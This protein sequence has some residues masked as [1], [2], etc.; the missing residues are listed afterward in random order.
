MNIEHWRAPILALICFCPP[1]LWGAY[2]CVYVHVLDKYVCVY[3]CICS[4]RV[5]IC[6]S[7]AY[8]YMYVFRCICICVGR[9][10]R[11]WGYR[12]VHD[13][14]PSMFRSINRQQIDATSSASSFWFDLKIQRTSFSKLM[15]VG[16]ISALQHSSRQKHIFLM[17]SLFLTMAMKL[18]QGK[19]SL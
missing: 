11:T 2:V 8:V 15:S 9:V 3:I 18:N 16:N 6:I 12:C 14:T 17:P 10:C 5:C 4:G 7:G 19:F 1:C 13:L